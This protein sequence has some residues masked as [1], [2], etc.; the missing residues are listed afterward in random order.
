VNRMPLLAVPRPSRVKAYVAARV[1]PP[2]ID[3]AALDAVLDRYCLSPV[4][5]RRNLRL[6]RRSA[7]VALA[8]GTGVK[9]IKQYRP[10]WSEATVQHGHSV[11]VELERA[12]FPAVRLTRT[13]DGDTWVAVGGRVYG[14][15]DLL[16]GSNYSLTYLR[17]GDRLALTRTAARTLGQL[18]DALRD[19]K[20]EAEHHM[21]FASRTGPP[22]RDVEWHAVA[23][24]DLCG[25]SREAM[26][27]GCEAPLFADPA[28]RSLATWLL[29]HAASVLDR[30]DRLER[31][32]ATAEFPRLV[33]HGDY[34]MHN[35]LYRDPQHASV[36]DFELTRLDWRVND[37]IS[38]VGKYRYSDGTHD[39][40]SMR[41]FFGAY[42]ANL[43]LVPDERRLFAHAWAL[44]KLKAGVQYWRSYFETGGPTRK[45][46]S[47]RDSILQADVVPLVPGLACAR[48]GMG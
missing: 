13:P 9:V 30:I 24:V 44:Y 40:Q 2:V 21:G 43:P 12:A 26:R 47:A 25:R 42:D 14:V 39:G 34:G 22:R 31:T 29:E 7:N 28:A 4:G 5:S 1:E 35:L 3:P 27:D 23:L 11:L 37:L 10:Q 17:R 20:P 16:A 19:F 48:D 8:T 32:L 6:G 15:F 45:L 41:A 36:I 46:Q 18:H 38:V 33:I